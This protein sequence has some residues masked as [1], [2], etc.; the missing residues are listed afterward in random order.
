MARVRPLLLAAGGLA[1]VLVLLA[2]QPAAGHAQGDPD[3][4][5]A[6][7]IR[8]LALRH[9]PIVYLRDQAR[10]CDRSGEAYDPAAVEIVLGE[11]TVVLRGIA[12]PM[13]APAAADIFGL[14]R[15][16]YLDFPGNPKRPGCTYERDFRRLSAGREPAVYA[17]VQKSGEA[18]YLQYW[19]FYYFNDWNNTHEGDWEYIQ[20]VF[21]ASNASE[22]LSRRPSR[23][24]YSQHAGGE[25]ADWNSKK[26]GREGDRPVVYVAKGSHANQFEPKLYLGLGEDGSGFGCD[27]ARAPH[28]R[29]DPRVV[30]LEEV[31]DSAGHPLAWL[32]FEG[33]W[34][35][36]RSGFYNGVT[37]PLQKRAWSD[38]EAWQSDTRRESIEVPGDGLLGQNYVE[39]FCGAV[40][41]SSRFY[42]LYQEWPIVVGVPSALAGALLLGLGAAIVW[43]FRR[44]AFA[45]G[46]VRSQLRQRRSLAQIIR[47]S[48]ALY[49]ARFRLFAGIGL[50]YIPVGLL[51][52]AG[53]QVVLRFRPVELLLDLAQ[54][55]RVLTVTFALSYGE[56]QTFIAFLFML[57][58]VVVAMERLD[59]GEPVGPVRAYAMA[60]KS[61]LRLAAA[62]GAVFGMLIALAVSVVGIPIA[63]HRAVRWY[64]VEQEVLLEGHGPR[65]ARRASSELVAG[66][67][68]LAFRR[69]FAFGAVGMLVAPLS[70]LGL[71]LLTPLP[72]GWANIVGGAVHVV[73]LPFVAIGLTLIYYDLRASHA[74]RE[75]R[76]AA[77]AA[78][79]DLAGR[80]S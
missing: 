17:S 60:A 73:V 42:L 52:A 6:T 41:L 72:I 26:L 21:E 28:R 63:V 69:T 76:E 48:A 65:G 38:P 55:S 7:A 74:E 1:A 36:L 12:E 78:A 9:A 11:E 15:E 59:R 19:F 4:D 33:R 8:Q 50:A 43:D 10:E 68:F 14:G 56:A 54:D 71:L 13:R 67:W 23:I 2:G 80:R 44:P 64:F 20:L 32:A 66:R 5:E 39:F 58:A 16:T 45:A 57:S 24:G 30:L 77:E 49:H 29:L 3:G 46:D 70:V 79:N 61:F 75:Q 35:E 37:G 22:A 31:P 47:A 53:Q 62:L 51:A 25:W 34:G 40:S 27:D 18:V